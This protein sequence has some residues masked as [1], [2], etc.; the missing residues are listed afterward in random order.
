M[1]VIPGPGRFVSCEQCR[2]LSRTWNVSDVETISRPLHTLIKLERT[3]GAVSGL[4]CPQREGKCTSCLCGGCGARRAAENPRS[5]CLC[6]CARARRCNSEA[7][8]RS[9]ARPPP[10]NSN[11]CK[12]QEEAEARGPEGAEFGLK[13]LRAEGPAFIG[14]SCVHRWPAQPLRQRAPSM[15]EKN[16]FLKNRLARAPT[17]TCG[18]DCEFQDVQ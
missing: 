5:R 8:P 15:V 11:H 3:T 6:A 1:A 2:Q 7:S 17:R 13:T 14:P 4:Q 16:M 9:E 10:H 18:P 12:E